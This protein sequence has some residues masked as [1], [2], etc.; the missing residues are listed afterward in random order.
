MT[1]RVKA[2]WDNPGHWQEGQIFDVHTDEEG[3]LWIA[4]NEGTKHRLSDSNDWDA[5]KADEIHRDNQFEVIS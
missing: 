1:L 3:Y 2:K 5:I 4:C